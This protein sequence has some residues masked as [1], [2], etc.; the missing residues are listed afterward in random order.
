MNHCTTVLPQG[1]I[2]MMISKSV[3]WWFIFSQ[4]EPEWDSN[5]RPFD[6][7]SRE[8]TTTPQ[9]SLRD[10]LSWWYPSHDDSDSYNMAATLEGNQDYMW[11]LLDLLALLFAFRIVA[12]DNLPAP[13]MRRTAG[14]IPSLCID[15]WPALVA[16]CICRWLGENNR[17][18]QRVKTN[19]SINMS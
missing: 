5:P 13:P 3:T 7:K 8:W 16:P 2:I 1:W 15:R 17:N 12:S 10:E 11:S 9:C 18:V 4:L 19:W 14:W 6:Y